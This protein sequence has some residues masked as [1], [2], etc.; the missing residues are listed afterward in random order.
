MT[1]TKLNDRWT[2]RADLVLRCAWLRG[3]AQQLFDQETGE[4]QG[5]LAAQLLDLADLL[6]VADRQGWNR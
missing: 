1:W 4:D 3:T 6:E 2:D 5:Y